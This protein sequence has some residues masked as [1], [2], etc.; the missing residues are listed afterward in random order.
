MTHK[1]SVGMEEEVAWT[2]LIGGLNMPFKISFHCGGGEDTYHVW[3]EG[4]VCSL[5]MP[6]LEAKVYSKLCFSIPL[7]I[8]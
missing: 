2:N 3:V 7:H 5:Q 4:L 6:S 8:K 1:L